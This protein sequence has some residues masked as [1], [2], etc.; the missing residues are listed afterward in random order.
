MAACFSDFAIFGGSNT[1]TGNG[2]PF[3]NAYGDGS[4]MRDLWIEHMSSAFWVGGS[5][6]VTNRLTI[7][8]CRIRNLGGDGINLC[9]GTKNSTVVNTTVRSSGDDGIA[10]WSAPEYDGP[11]GG[12]DY[13]G[14]ANNVVKNCTVEL[15]WRANA[16]AIYGGKD[17]TI[18]DCI[19]RDTLTYAGVN[20]SSTFKPRPFTGE[21][22]VE[23]VLIE[24]CG[25]TFW[26]GQQ[27]GAVWVMADDL[28]IP[29][30][31]FKNVRI[32][33]P[34]YSGI[35][36][37]SETYNKSSLAEMHA[38]FENVTVVKPGTQGI[39]VQD[40]IGST[41]FKNTKLLELPTKSILRNRDTNGKNGTGTIA[42]TTDSECAGIQE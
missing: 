24:R 25:G 29:N 31:V 19:A 38:T 4:V 27:F 3:N 11:A 40:S 32:V 37:K 35:M 33:E 36:L 9:N 26:N 34:T 20:I 15:P 8:R 16:F 17:N 28:K 42:F 30:A 12:I 23:N 41:N 5:S 14:C 7:D 22:R 10:I 21:T 13:A 1:R 2:K 6:G 39:L 18:R